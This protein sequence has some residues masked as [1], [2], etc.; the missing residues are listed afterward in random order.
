MKF[1]QGSGA[2]LLS[3]CLLTLV[4]GPACS[5]QD[6]SSGTKETVATDDGGKSTAPESGDEKKD[7]PSEEAADPATIPPNLKTDAFAYYGLDNSKP[8]KF[9]MTAS[10]QSPMS[11]EQTVKFLGMKDGKATYNVERTG[12]LAANMGS[13]EMELSEKG[14]FVTSTTMGSIGEPTLELPSTL[15]AGDTWKLDQKL[16][17]TGGQTI[18]TKSV[19]KVVGVQK[20]KTKGGD[21]DALLITATGPATYAGNTVQ[22]EMK[23]WYAKGYGAVKSE[24]TTK[25][26]SGKTSK[27]L[28]ELTK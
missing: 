19:Y 27:V 4:V 28:I 24:I 2:W 7:A 12:D 20:V 5:P 26:K 16:E 9:E 18:E 15:K 25:D 3:F 11:G 1:W 8:L 13:Q 17:T 14:L 6:K 10:G 22:M 23:A 21:F